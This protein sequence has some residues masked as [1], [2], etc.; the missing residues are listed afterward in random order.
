MELT[1]IILCTKLRKNNDVWLTILSESP[2]GFRPVFKPSLLLHRG[3]QG[4]H[5]WGDGHVLPADIATKFLARCLLQ[6]WVRDL[7]DDL[8]EL[9][10]CKCDTDAS[11]SCVAHA[12]QPLQLVIG[13]E[14]F[15]F[16]L[17]QIRV[18]MVELP[19]V[20]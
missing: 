16:V 15:A 4:F 14:V 12:N 8:R 6:L 17:L 9:V 2:A 18:Y 10:N 7:A 11:D 1:W 13:Q 20:I 19:F 3:Q 5:R